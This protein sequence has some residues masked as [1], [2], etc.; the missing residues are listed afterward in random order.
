MEAANAIL[1]RAQDARKNAVSMACRAHNS[2]KSMHQKN[3]DDQIEMLR[4]KG[5]NFDNDY[6]AED[7]HGVF[8]RRVTS[9]KEI[10]NDT[11]AKIP[12]SQKPESRSVMRSSVEQLDVPYFGDIED[13]V[14]FIFG[15]R[16]E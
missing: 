14:D 12:D 4:V 1:W 5:I 13:R 9:L 10:D 16:N 2:A 6:P 7:R 3:R 15:E 11:W 8:F